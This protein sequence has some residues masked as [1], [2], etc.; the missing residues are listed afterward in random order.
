MDELAGLEDDWSV[1]AQASL[2]A[3]TTTTSTQH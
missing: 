1:P 3:A 2:N